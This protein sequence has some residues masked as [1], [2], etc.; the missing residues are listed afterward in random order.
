MSLFDR[1]FKR[2]PT[3]T[4]AKHYEEIRAV[5]SEERRAG[6]E[7]GKIQAYREAKETASKTA[8]M[9]ELINSQLEKAAVMCDRR[10]EHAG[11]YQHPLM[12]GR[13]NEALSIAKD[14][15]GMKQK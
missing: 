8:I 1:I 2:E 3:I 12:Q 10:A 13:M 9:K 6:Y 14:I 5:R 7:C 15:R 11:R 4:L